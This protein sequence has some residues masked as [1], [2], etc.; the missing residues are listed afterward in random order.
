MM[1]DDDDMSLSPKE[2]LRAMRVLHTALSAGAALFALI[3]FAVIQINGSPVL[4]PEYIK[5]TGYVLLAG[6]VL[7][8][9]FCFFRAAAA[10]KKDVSRVKKEDSSLMNKLNHYRGILIMYLAICEAAAFFSV[11]VYF[12]TGDLKALI[13]AAIMLIAMIMKVPTQKRITEDLGLNWRDL[14]KF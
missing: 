14:Q 11:I 4:E 2:H 8:A 5:K 12:L 9:A 13:I 7:L 3:A 6:A 10:Y 1:R